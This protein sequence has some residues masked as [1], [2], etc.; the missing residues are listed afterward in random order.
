[1]RSL[2]R[3]W[4]DLPELKAVDHNW[5]RSPG[6][7]AIKKLTEAL[8]YLEPVIDEARALLERA[9]AVTAKANAM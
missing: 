8:A 1:M 6:P 4:G 3:R 9:V 7:P 5:L 2:A